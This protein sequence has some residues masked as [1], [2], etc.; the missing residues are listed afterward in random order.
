MAVESS[1]ERCGGVVELSW[2]GLRL[3][4]SGGARAEFQ[5]P[6]SLNP[7]RSF[8]DLCPASR[9][10]TRSSRVGARSRPASHRLLPRSLSSCSLVI[11]THL[12]PQK[13]HYAVCSC[14]AHRPQ[15]LRP[16]F[17]RRPDCFC[18]RRCY[19][20]VRAIDAHRATSP[21]LTPSP[22]PPTAATR[23]R[24]PSPRPERR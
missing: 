10:R 14:P 1:F 11:N 6:E 5:I 13:L 23:S 22:L 16:A 7:A 20:N 17:A 4:R 18:H 9:L 2:R 12:P 24:A 3:A 8:S 15:G 19:W 21:S